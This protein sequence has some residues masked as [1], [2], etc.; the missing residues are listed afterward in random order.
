MSFYKRGR[1]K[2]RQSPKWKY[3]SDKPT[4]LMWCL[5]EYMDFT[6]LVSTNML[7]LGLCGTWISESLCPRWISSFVLPQLL[8]CVQR[9]DKPCIVR[10]SLAYIG[11]ALVVL[12]PLHCTRCMCG[13][14]PLFSQQY[15]TAADPLRLRG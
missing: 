10:V 11:H 4:P 12:P 8:L 6:S 3:S 2:T 7:R 13:Y 5:A 15:T 9:I 1:G 14:V